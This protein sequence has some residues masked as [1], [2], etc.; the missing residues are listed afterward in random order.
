MMR[1]THFRARREAEKR[2]LERK[3]RTAVR[4]DRMGGEREEGTR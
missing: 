2:N 3:E 1:R 4:M